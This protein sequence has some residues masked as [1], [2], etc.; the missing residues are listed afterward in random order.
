MQK[1]LLIFNLASLIWSFLFWIITHFLIL[2]DNA[3]TPQIATHLTILISLILTGLIHFYLRP[4]EQQN[5]KQK[6]FLSLLYLLYEITPFLE[7]I[8]DINFGMAAFGSRK[9]HIIIFRTYYLLLK[10]VAF[11][12]KKRRSW[13]KAVLINII[14]IFIMITNICLIC[15]VEEEE[16]IILIIISDL[17]LVSSCLGT[18]FFFFANKSIYFNPHN[19]FDEICGP[20]IQPSVIFE[21]KRKKKKGNS[22]ENMSENFSYEIIITNLK[23]YDFID[24]P[25][26]KIAFN[27][28]NEKFSNFK[29]HSRTF[30]ENETETKTYTHWNY[31][32]GKTFNSLIDL[33]TFV[34]NTKREDK[35]TFL[36]E[37]QQPRLKISIKKVIRKNR[38]YFILVIRKLSSSGPNKMNENNE[39]K[40]RLLQTISH[41]LKT[42]LNASISILELLRTE[43]GGRNDVYIQNSLSS[44]KLLETTL[45]NF[46]DYSL[47]NSDEFILGMSQVNILNL[48]NEIFRITQAQTN[49]K[50][51]DYKIEI[52]GVL[53]NKNIYT[54]FPRLKQIILNI[55]LNAIQFTNKGFIRVEILVCKEKPLTIEFIITDSGIGMDCEF[56][57]NIKRKLNDE[58][59]DFQANSTGSC[60]GL[61]ISNKLAFLLG[62]E[63][64]SFESKVNEGTKINFKV[65]D[66]NPEIEE[67]EVRTPLIL[68]NKIVISEEKVASL[69]KF[70]ESVKEFSNKIDIMRR[71][72]KTMKKTLPPIASYSKLENSENIIT[73][74]FENGTCPSKLKAIDEHDFQS[75]I[76]PVFWNNNSHYFHK[77]NKKI[78]TDPKFK[79]RKSLFQVN[80]T[81]DVCI[82]KDSLAKYDLNESNENSFP[83]IILKSQGN[84]F[85]EKEACKTNLCDGCNQILIVDDDAFNLF[86][87]DLILKTFNQKCV[88]AMNGKEALDMVSFY[89]KLMYYFNKRLL[90][91]F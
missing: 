8:N 78:P 39:Y 12:L 40:V 86:S 87:L 21:E 68:G 90:L 35:M 18:L 36:R 48:M 14:F 61:T 6:I 32:E 45:N 88:K 63:G 30:F 41:E 7:M 26:K 3:T 75:I 55:I 38:T 51:L 81:H 28:I 57:E 65:Y 59:F 53:A 91:Q 70:F 11:S 13:R 89:E 82:S 50:N 29:L 72:N 37:D 83:T 44:L 2:A 79:N 42:P 15:G 85:L 77:I 4:K 74:S 43:Y 9:P 58:N 34:K 5:K 16:Q 60:M 33:L 62:N 31:K 67:E 64:L 66:R 20:M 23:F 56:L 54:D 19:Y 46:I 1:I 10:C 76:R 49:L 71:K 80:H 69:N 52:P 24:N 84:L 25:K 47:I 22:Y 27:D 73:E 17:I